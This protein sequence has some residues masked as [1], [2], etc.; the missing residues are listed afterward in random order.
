MGF[1][2][3]ELDLTWQHIR[4]LQRLGLARRIRLAPVLVSRSALRSL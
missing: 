1:R 4:L 2:W 3:W